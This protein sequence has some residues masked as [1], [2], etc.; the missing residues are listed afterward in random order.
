MSNKEIL[1]NPPPEDLVD[2]VLRKLKIFKDICSTGYSIPPH[3]YEDEISYTV[4]IN[5]TPRGDAPIRVREAWVELVIPSCRRVK[6]SFNSH[7]GS[8]FSN[9]L[10]EVGSGASCFIQAKTIDA[11][12][13]LIRNGTNDDYEAAD[14][15][16]SQHFKL[17]P[18]LYFRDD[19]VSILEQKK[20]P[21]NRSY[22][23]PRAN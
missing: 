6:P 5:K 20:L 15:F 8:F 21:A 18:N 13:A 9:E 4:L 17:S 1:S 19:E 10:V 12:E 2:R 14:W 23:N 16:L 7:L 11:L 22:D 3:F